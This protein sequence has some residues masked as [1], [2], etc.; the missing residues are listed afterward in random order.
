MMKP[1]GDMW[2]M[3]L[4]GETWYVVY[5]RNEEQARSEIT[6]LRHGSGDYLRWV[7]AGCPVRL[8]GDSR[9]RYIGSA[10]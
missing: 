2:D 5:A 3:L 9:I 8:V 4:D 1:V 7:S 6:R 10:Q